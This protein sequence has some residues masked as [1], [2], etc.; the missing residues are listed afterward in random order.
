M[1]EKDSGSTFTIVKD[2]IDII[3]EKWSHIEPLFRCSDFK[4]AGVLTQSVE[5]LDSPASLSG[6]RLDKRTPQGITGNIGPSPGALGWGW[7]NWE[8]A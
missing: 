2:H 4:T 6:Q 7:Q 3:C 1:D 5:V 8:K